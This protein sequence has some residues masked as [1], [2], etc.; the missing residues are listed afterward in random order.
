MSHR[1]ARTHDQ[2]DGQVGNIM[3]SA[4]HWIDG[5]RAERKR[6]NNGEDCE[7]RESEKNW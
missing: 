4:A 2:M 6:F 5:G 1:H 3:L 7:R